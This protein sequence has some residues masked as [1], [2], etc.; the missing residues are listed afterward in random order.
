MTSLALTQSPPPTPVSSINVSVNA[1]QTVVRQGESITI[2][3]IVMGNDVVNFQWT[4]PRMKVM[5]GE[6]WKAGQTSRLP[7]ASDLGTCPCRVGGWWSR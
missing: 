7:L 4:Y 6:A 5:L 2:K 3:C 1:V